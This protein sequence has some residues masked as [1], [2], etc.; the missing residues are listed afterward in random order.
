MKKLLCFFA[1]TL[2]AATALYAGAPDKTVVAPAASNSP[3]YIGID[4]G[5]NLNQDNINDNG[6]NAKKQIGWTAGLKGGYLFGSEQ[7]FVRPAVELEGLYTSFGRHLDAPDEMPLTLKARVG[8]W[9]YMANGIAN[10][11]LGCVQPYVGAGVGYFASKLKVSAEYGEG[12][13]PVLST[14][15]DGFAWQLLAG[16]NVPVTSS[17]SVFTEYKWLNCT[18]RNRNEFVTGC[19]KLGQQLLVAG[20]KF[21]F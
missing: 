18:I 13:H 19:G 10:F 5:L 4:G 2:S 16:V 14:E 17:V 7:D 21:S 8:T 11:N 1:V 15:R 6:W 20:V 12:Q 9:A 3:F